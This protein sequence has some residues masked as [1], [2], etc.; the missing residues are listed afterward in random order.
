MRK[1]H[2]WESLA[3]MRQWLPHIARLPL[4]R[5]LDRN[6]NA[7][8]IVNLTSHSLSHRLQC[9]P[10]GLLIWGEQRQHAKGCRFQRTVQSGC[11]D[12]P[13]NGASVIFPRAAL[14]MD[15]DFLRCTISSIFCQGGVEKSSLMVCPT[16][17]IALFA[18]L[19]APSI[20]S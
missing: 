11:Y 20:R 12:K 4:A 6:I 19:F 15:L 18:I 2:M 9:N 7:M 14:Q 8:Y 17:D 5:N 16:R 3:R 10:L 13:A 1:V